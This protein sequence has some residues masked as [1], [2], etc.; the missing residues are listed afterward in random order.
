MKHNL[1]NAG[2]QLFK[3]CIELVFFYFK[4]IHVCFKN[5]EHPYNT[6]FIR[7]K[8]KHLWTT[9]DFVSKHKTNM[10][11]KRTLYCDFFQRGKRGKKIQ[12]SKEMFATGRKIRYF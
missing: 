6:L 8:R 4:E 1:K 3:V 2:I 12:N 7:K 9:M 10:S 5:D 11:E